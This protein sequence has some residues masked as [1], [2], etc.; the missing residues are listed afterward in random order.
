MGEIS[1]FAPD[2]HEHTKSGRWHLPSPA[3]LSK[4]RS[5]VY[6]SISALL[7]RFLYASTAAAAPMAAAGAI[8]VLVSAV[9]PAPVLGAS[10]TQRS[11]STQ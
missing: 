4:V 10:E 6:A 5:E 2:A 11:S 1:L 8:Q 7:S 3:S 9:V